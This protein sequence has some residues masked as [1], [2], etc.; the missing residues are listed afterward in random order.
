MSANRINTP[1]KPKEKFQE[2]LV[3]KSTSRVQAAGRT[4]P[5]PRAFTFSDDDIERSINRDRSRRTFSPMSIKTL[6]VNPGATRLKKV[7]EAQKK[8]A[9]EREAVARTSLLRS[10]GVVVASGVVGGVQGPIAAES[11]TKTD[12]KKVSNPKSVADSDIEKILDQ[13]T[14]DTQLLESIDKQFPKDK[15]LEPTDP[16]KIVDMLFNGSAKKQALIPPVGTL[17]TVS[18]FAHRAPAFIPSP[19]A[20]VTQLLDTVP[21]APLQGY[22]RLGYQRV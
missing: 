21:S 11:K 20:G 1:V 17:S 13:I 3:L 9:E 10:S 22:R 18:R 16:D 2:V 15:L 5:V 7:K 19:D 6:L 14:M 12:T 4:L 8:E